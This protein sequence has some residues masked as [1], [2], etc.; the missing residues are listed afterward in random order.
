M[1]IRLLMSL[2]ILL[3]AAPSLLA[4]GQPPPPKLSQVQQQVT[5]Q[6]SSLDKT[7]S[8]AALALSATND[9]IGVREILFNI[10]ANNQTVVDA[11]IVSPAG[12]ITQVEPPTYRQAIGSDISQ[13]AHIIKLVKTGRP[14][15]SGTFKTVE[16]FYAVSLGYPIITS[17]EVKGYLS[18]IFKP[19]ALIRNV[20]KGYQFEPNVSF[21]AIEPTGRVIY[22]QDIL[23]IGRMTFADPMYRNS[24]TLLKLA[25]QVISDAT[26]SGTYEYQS[27]KRAEWTTISL[28]GTVWRLLV[29]SSL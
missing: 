4:M 22:D 10:F 20:L 9:K 15:L 14:V 26:G 2:L 6:L 24:P 23:Q 13:Q 16:G 18:V 19:D 29:T 27:T 25:Q 12:I 1:I 3:T 17:T 5:E 11:V 28:H 8:T 7:V 21:M